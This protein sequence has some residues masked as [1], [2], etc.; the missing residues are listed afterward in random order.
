LAR[1]RRSGVWNARE[2]SADYKV[3][4]ADSPA[5][6]IGRVKP[7][8]PHLN[9]ILGFPFQRSPRRGQFSILFSRHVSKHGMEEINL[10]LARQIAGGEAPPRAHR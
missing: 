9:N 4:S 1:A 8:R 6:Q 10:G 7:S 3:K 5:I 2:R